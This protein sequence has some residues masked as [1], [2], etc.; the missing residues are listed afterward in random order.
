M[1]KIQC[2]RYCTDR[3]MSCHSF[4]ERYIR[5]RK[6]L[7][8]RKRKIHKERENDRILAPSIKYH[9]GRL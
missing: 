4:C 3:T 7:E 6:E 5:E 9:N 8:E 2:C 1:K